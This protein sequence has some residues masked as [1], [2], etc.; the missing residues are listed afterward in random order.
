MTLYYPSLL[1][2]TR[3]LGTFIAARGCG[4]EQTLEVVAA[5]AARA[6]VRGDARVALR[7][8]DPRQS[9]LDVNV[10]DGHRLFASDVARVGLEEPSQM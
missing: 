7:R 8:L 3:R 6:Q 4:R 5:R 10:Q 9:Q 1:Q 2:W